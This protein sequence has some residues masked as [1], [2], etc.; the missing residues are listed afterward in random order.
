MEADD[1]LNITDVLGKKYLQTKL[2]RT[3]KIEEEN[4]IAALELMSRFAADPHWLIYLPPTM[5]PCE[6]SVLP[7]Y[8]EHPYEAFNY[9]KTHGVE[10]VICQQK[11]MGSRAV[12]V[13]CKDKAT[14]EKRFGITDDRFGI[15][16]TR[17]GRPFFDDRE[18]EN[19]ILTRLQNTLTA[20]SFWDD[21]N[22]GWLCIDT[23]LMPWSAK[24]QALLKE[25]YAQSGFAG[26]NSLSMA[27]NVISDAIVTLG[28][29]SNAGQTQTNADLE[30]LLAKY[31]EREE[32]LNLY[33]DAYRRY[34]WDVQRIDDYRIAPFHI[35]ATEGK[36]WNTENHLLHME[37]IT[38]YMTGIDPVFMPT[39]HLTIDL[40]DE[41]NIAKGIQW[42]E[43]L[44]ASGG[45][46]MVV[47]PLDFI[48]KKGMQLLQPA[49]K[50]RGREYL[51]II[52]S[53]EYLLNNNLEILKKRY[54]GKK[55]N[56]ALNE[57]A[58]GME[59]LER[60]TSNEA[61]YR[62]HECVFGILALESEPVDPRL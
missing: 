2:R 38:R 55:R 17:T 26:R 25:Q 10:K 41:K 3:V 12:I 13:L 43:E 1:L 47:K 52:Y 56:L 37:Y 39:D 32:A 18:T 51:R 33:T 14:A 62:V 8:L 31:T 5:S 23:E 30:S 11:H 54:L 53:P 57:F 46:G 58:L 20:S 45:E 7:D 19:A 61:L 15:I 44:T 21:F 9:Y 28:K 36:T 59:A 6:T 29:H 49:I 24:A 16:Y 42:W 48:A 60:F 22:T 35:L 4:S 34:C 40:T 50:C 27:R